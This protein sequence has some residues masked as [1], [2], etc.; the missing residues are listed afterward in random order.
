MTEPSLRRNPLI[1]KPTG[2]I[3]RRFTSPQGMNNFQRFISTCGV[4]AVAVVVPGAWANVVAAEPTSDAPCIAIVMPVVQGMTGNAADA[5]TGVRDLIAGY[6]SGP[7]VKLVSLEARLPSQAIEE[8]KQK[9]CEPLLFATVTR[10]SGGSRLTKALGQA[11]GNSA[12]YLPGGGSVASAAGRVA[13]V[14]GLQAASSLASSTKAKDEMR[15]EYRLQSAAGQIQF[16][17]KSES[18]TATADGEDLLTPVVMRAAEAIV[19][20]G[21]HK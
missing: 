11:A 6:L 14:G 5:A 17:P 20:R 4:I 16:G 21:G 13:A 7:S 19:T 10:K 1:K 8:A 2:N 12:W 18:Q 15:L 3:A 9:G